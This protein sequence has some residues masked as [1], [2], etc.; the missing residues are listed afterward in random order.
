MK[1]LKMLD[2]ALVHFQPNSMFQQDVLKFHFNFVYTS[3]FSQVT[4]YV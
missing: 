2:T 4:P 3:N 1:I